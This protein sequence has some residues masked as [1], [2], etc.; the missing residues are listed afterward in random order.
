MARP[1]QA[2]APG[3]PDPPGSMISRA[4]LTEASGALSLRG[5]GGPICYAPTRS[6]PNG[7]AEPSKCACRTYTFLAFYGRNFF[8]GA[9][10]NLLD[11][12]AGILCPPTTGFV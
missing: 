3:T 11:M 12:A 9:G 7:A 8:G 1:C 4:P 10:F 6:A 5:P 2:F